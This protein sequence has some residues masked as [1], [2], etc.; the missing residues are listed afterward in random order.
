MLAQD[1]EESYERKTGALPRERELMEDTK[2]LSHLYQEKKWSTAA[3]ISVLIPF[4]I[5]PVPLIIGEIHNLPK[6]RKNG[7]FPWELPTDS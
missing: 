2:H 5:V 1:I 4:L 7:S 6:K 3:S